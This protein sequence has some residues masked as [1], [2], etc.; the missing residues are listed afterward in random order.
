[1]P[2]AWEE[3][4]CITAYEGLA[5]GAKVLCF[6]GSGNLSD[7]ADKNKDVIA[8]ENIKKMSEAVHTI[9]DSTIIEK[10][11]YHIKNNMNLEYAK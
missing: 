7:L 4:F 10:N 2:S 3:T 6:K 9:Y 11:Y 8:F 1:M 5:G